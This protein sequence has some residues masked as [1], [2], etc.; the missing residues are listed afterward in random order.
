VVSRSRSDFLTAL[1][2]TRLAAFDV[3]RRRLRVEAGAPRAAEGALN[4][5]REMLRVQRLPS[6]VGSAPAAHRGHDRDRYRSSWSMSPKSTTSRRP[7]NYVRL[8]GTAPSAL[9]REHLALEDRLDP[10]R[11]ARVTAR[12]RQP[13]T[14][15]EQLEP[16]AFAT[17][18]SFSV[19]ARSFRF[20]PLSGPAFPLGRK[21]VTP[22]DSAFERRIILASQ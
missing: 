20:P 14:G 16:N 18:G 21:A 15:V 19:A 11:F 4:R 1:T 7:G 3:V 12:D 22:E 17:T 6:E 10:D 9:P 5:R 13:S 2:S 8:H